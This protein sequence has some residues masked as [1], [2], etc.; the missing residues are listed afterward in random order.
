MMSGSDLMC[1]GPGEFCE[2]CKMV[3]CLNWKAGAGIGCGGQP[4]DGLELSFNNSCFGREERD[5]T[6][7]KRERRMK[8]RRAVM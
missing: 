8:R 3:Y 4:V 1:D 5:P 7:E 2:G 6:G